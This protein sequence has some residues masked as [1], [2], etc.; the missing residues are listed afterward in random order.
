MANELISKCTLDDSF[1]V[2]IQLEH[3]LIAFVQ[4]AFIMPKGDRKVELLIESFHIAFPVVIKGEHQRLL[5]VGLI[6][7][8]CS[9]D[10]G[11]VVF[12]VLD[13]NLQN[14]VQVI[15]ASPDA[16]EAHWVGVCT[17][18]FPFRFREW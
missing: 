17:F 11:E 7:S 2:G 18:I 13:Q 6:G 1:F 3:D 9:F 15:T 16:L 8:Q 5:S 12:L 10:E 14:H 4:Y